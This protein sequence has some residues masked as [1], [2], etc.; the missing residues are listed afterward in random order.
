MKNEELLKQT[1]DKLHASPDTLTE[2]LKMTT[3]KNTV[4]Y[5]NK[6]V[7]KRTVLLAATLVIVLG[8]A[9]IAYAT[10]LGGIQTAIKLWIGGE[11]VDATVSFRE[12]EYIHDDG[13][14]SNLLEYEMEYEDADGNV[15]SRGG[16]GIVIED[17]G[18]IRPQTPEELMEN[19]VVPEVIYEENGKT[20]ICYK[21]QKVDVTDF[22][23]DGVCKYEMEID[24]EKMYF[25]IT[26]NGFAINPNGYEDPDQFNT[27]E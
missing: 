11:Q 4:K 13:T 10:D 9:S 5:K 21:E 23:V 17:D 15:Q 19:L 2:V 6:P 22:Y 7:M 18:N 26:E 16:G 12:A 14:V 24:G 3:E 8:F 20:F 27:E 1:F 25:T